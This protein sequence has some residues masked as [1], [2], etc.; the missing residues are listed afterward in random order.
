M[1]R[2]HSAAKMMD[3]RESLLHHRSGAL[4]DG[5][6]DGEKEAG[7]GAAH[8]G[9]GNVPKI[10]EFFF[11]FLL[12]LTLCGIARMRQGRKGALGNFRSARA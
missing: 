10:V 9:V 8:L 3:P 5:D 7:N 4:P 2:P 6:L 11:S 12:S 1:A